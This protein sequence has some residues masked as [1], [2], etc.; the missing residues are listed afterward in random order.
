MNF[1]RKEEEEDREDGCSGG[2]EVGV[3]VRDYLDSD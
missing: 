2:E 3:G 1:L